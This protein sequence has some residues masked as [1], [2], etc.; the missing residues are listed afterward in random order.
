MARRST[1]HLPR[2]LEGATNFTKDR[3]ELNSLWVVTM[4]KAHPQFWGP[5]RKALAQADSQYGRPRL[6][7]DWALAYMAYAFSK[8]PDVQPW[9][10]Q[11][12]HSIWRHAGFRE[13]PSYAVTHR[14]F[15]ELEQHAD[16]FQQV[17]ELLIKHAGK[18]TGGEVGRYVHVDGTEAETHA[19][20]RHI[21]PKDAP[22][23]D[24]R[25]AMR[26]TAGESVNVVRAARHAQA[27][28]PEP[29]ADALNAPDLGDAEAVVEV[30]GA[31][32]VKVKDCWYELLDPT[33]GIRA[34]TYEGK[35]RRFWVGFYNAKAIDHYTGAPVAV[36]VT[37]ASVQEHISYPDLFAK[38][39]KNTGRM[40]E[41][42]VADRGYSISTV[43]EHNTTRGVASVMQWRRPNWKIEDRSQL[44]TDRHD[45]HGIPRCK[46]CG[47]P[48]RFVRF[49]E[50]SSVG[51][52][53]WV[54]CTTGDEGTDCAECEQTIQC[55]DDWTKLLPLWRT[56]E[57]YLALRNTH[58]QYERVH[59]HWRGRYRVAAD[60]HELRPKR[61]GRDCQQL[62]ANAALAIEWLIISWREGW[63]GSA[64]RARRFGEV[65][66]DRA[67][68]AARGFVARRTRYGLEQPYGPKAVE[69][70]IGELTPTA[71]RDDQIGDDGL[72]PP[73]EEP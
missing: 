45:R 64:R 15:A 50:K 9:W 47:G 61:R 2:R 68:E 25:S 62:R 30:A 71:G 42:V 13:R 23:R 10:G 33:A 21:C 58:N 17:A 26:V 38:A 22:C 60:D 59:H 31:I 67:V 40:P 32:R 24:K 55:K 49:S 34:Y 48:T 36:H 46:Y 19:R 52:R 6:P 54:R 43:F 16:A 63:L 12:G 72:G 57:T 37:S 7:G 44:D 28:E 4:L 11:A 20:L 51:P 18:Q 14:R 8:I 41:A 65:V 29:Q 66:I 27:K 70:K 56:E 5:I 73:S 69:L 53:L 1:N 3:D 35:V 39:V